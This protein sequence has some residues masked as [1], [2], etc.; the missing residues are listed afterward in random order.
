MPGEIILV[1]EEVEAKPLMDPW[2]TKE[3]R[4]KGDMRWS[5]WGKSKTGMITEDKENKPPGQIGGGNA[6]VESKM[7]A[8]QPAI[9][10]KHVAKDEGN[11]GLKKPLKI[12]SN[13]VI[14]T[15]PPKGL[16]PPEVEKGIPTQPKAQGH[17]PWL[18]K[19]T[20]EER[21]EIEMAL[22]KH[23]MKEDDQDIVKKVKED[24]KPQAQKGGEKKEYD[25]R[26]P[27]E[28]KVK[29]G[30]K[31]EAKKQHVKVGSVKEK[32]ENSCTEDLFATS[33]EGSKKLEKGGPQKGEGSKRK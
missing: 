18:D 16:K 6:T 22:R 32:S 17:I 3:E 1:K 11:S 26:K 28:V 27:Q 24:R 21:I 33:S 13:I 4:E 9:G 14:P 5:T 8:G 20:K 12:R 15:C 7:G 19:F 31:P 25:G 29:Q 23:G 2:M 30:S 10:T